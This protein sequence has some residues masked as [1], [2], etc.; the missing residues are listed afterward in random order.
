MHN[1]DNLLF[2]KQIVSIFKTAVFLIYLQG[3]DIQFQEERKS[4]MKEKCQGNLKP[5]G[6]G[7]YF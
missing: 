4:H 1:F 7:L 6:E 5:K 3:L 2:I